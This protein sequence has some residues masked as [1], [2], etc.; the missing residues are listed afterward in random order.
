MHAEQLTAPDADHGEGPVWWHA[1]GGLCW[2]DMLRGDVLRLLQNGEV[3]RWH[4]GSVAA[5]IRPH[6]GAGF[7]I[8]TEDS[9]V[10]ASLYG[11]PV[12]ALATAFTDS[13]VRFNEG[14]CDPLGNF[15]C[16]TMRYDAAHGGGRVLRLRPDLTVDL[17]L[18]EVTV[19]NGLQ[20]TADGTHAYYVDSATQ[21]IDVFDHDPSHGLHARRQFVTVAPELGIPDG[22]ALDASGGVWVALFGGGAIHRYAADGTLSEVVDVPVPQVTSCTFGGPEG[23]ELFVTTSRYGQGDEAPGGAVYVCDAGVAGLPLLGFG[24]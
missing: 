15:L 5:A 1:W 17:V 23:R 13:T 24:G 16:G 7:V 22:L 11:E 18:D 12:R 21:R 6:G 8:A 19:S 4:V 9:F 3:E 10:G 2:L 14:A 20:W